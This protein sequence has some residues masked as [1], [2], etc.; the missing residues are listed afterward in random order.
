MTPSVSYSCYIVRVQQFEGD[1]RKSVTKKWETV[2][3]NYLKKTDKLRLM[4]RE[5]VIFM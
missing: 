2:E 1:L 4:L 3:K 5:R